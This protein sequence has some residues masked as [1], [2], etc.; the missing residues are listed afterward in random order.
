MFC[1]YHMYTNCLYGIYTITFCL[2]EVYKTCH[3]LVQ[4]KNICLYQVQ[5][6]LFL[7]IPDIDNLST[8]P[9]DKLSI[10]CI[11]KRFLFIQHIDNFFTCGIYKLSLSGMD[12]HNFFYIK[13]GNLSVYHIDNCLVYILYRQNFHMQYIQRYFFPQLIS[14]ICL[15]HIQTKVYLYILH[16]E[17]LSIHNIEKYH[18]VQSIHKI[19]FCY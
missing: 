7:S 16:M 2:Y 3:N 1:L 13:Y 4:T 12:K 8:Y 6:N 15:Y 14:T 10:Y 5:T 9:I 11:D 18:S 17:I 19:Y